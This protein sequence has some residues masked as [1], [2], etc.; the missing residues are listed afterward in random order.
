MKTNPGGITLKNAD[1]LVDN[2]LI[3]IIGVQIESH[4]L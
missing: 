3:Q 4:Y 1:K 2:D